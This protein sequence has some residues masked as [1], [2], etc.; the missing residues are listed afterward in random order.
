M[1]DIDC[2]AIAQRDRTLLYSAGDLKRLERSVG[3]DPIGSAL[4]PVKCKLSVD[5]VRRRAR[6]KRCPETGHA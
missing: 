5:R 4:C 3:Q 6:I 1:S 2:T